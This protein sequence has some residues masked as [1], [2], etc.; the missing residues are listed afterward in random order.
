MLSRQEL[1]Q[2]TMENPP[3]T[4]LERSSEIQEKY[5]NFM[6]KGINRSGFIEN[7]KCRLQQEEF[8]FVQNDFPYHTTPNIEHWVCWYGKDTDPKK[9]VGELKQ[10]NKIIT[11]WKNHSQNMSI[12]EVN[13]IHVFIQR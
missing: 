10:K 6:R 2:Y 13:H 7:M 4:M 12:Q 8:H 1:I 5:D 11:Y 9:I 3:M